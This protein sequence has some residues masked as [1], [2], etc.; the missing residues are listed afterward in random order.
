MSDVVGGSERKTVS[1]MSSHFLLHIHAISP[2]K[3]VAGKTERE[4]GENRLSPHQMP[5][6][7]KCN[8]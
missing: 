5:H 8:T 1:V 4:S 7:I 2:Q 3:Q 6:F